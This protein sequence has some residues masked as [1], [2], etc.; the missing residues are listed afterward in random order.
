ML[1]LLALAGGARLVFANDTLVLGQAQ[2]GNIFLSSEPV[3]IPLQTTGDQISW[4]A[5]DFFGAVTTAPAMNVTNGQATVQPALGRLGFFKLHVTALRN[6]SP[7]AAADTML[8]VLAP[9]NVGAMHDSPFGINTHFAQGWSTDLMPLLARGGIAHFRDEQYWQNVEPARSLPATYNFT[10]YD[11]Y[12][13]A[14][15]AN[16][17]DPLLTLDFANS[18]YDGGYSPYTDEGR[19]GFANYG[20]ALISHA[21]SQIDTVAIWNE[22]NGSYATGPAANDRP[23]SYTS[24][25]QTAYTAIKAQHP[26]VRVVGGACVPVPLPWF[27]ELFSRGALDYLDAIDAH[28]YRSIP[29]GVENELAAVQALSA[30]YNHGRGPKPI[31]ATECG[32]DD[33]AHP[34]RE[35]MARYLVRL[36]TLMRTAGVERAYWYVAY[37]YD[38]YTTGLLHG[39]G[40]PLGAY[41][42]TSAFSAYSALIQQLYGATYVSR[43]QTDARTRSYYF[44]RGS[45]DV[46]VVW[47]TAGTAQLV[48]TTSTPLTRINIMG[49]ST[50]LQPSN[51]AVVVTADGDPY[52]LVGPVDAVR[53]IGRDT[54]I[55]DTVRDF[56][57]TQGSTAGNWSYSAT[58]TTPGSAYDPAALTPMTYTRTNF[59]YEFE[60]YFPF[61]KLDA[62]GGHPG[63]RLGYDPIYPVWSVRRWLSNTAANA[64]FNGTAVRAAIFGDGTGIKV[65]IDGAEVYSATLG[66]AGAAAT[67]TFDFDAPIQ[68]G[69]KV[70][71]VT[72]PGA[73]LDINYDYVDYRAVIS[74][75]APKPVVTVAATTAAASESGGAG[76]ITF[77]RTLTS[78]AL[79]VNYSL[80][81][82]ATA[83]IDYTASASSVTFPDGATTVPLTINPVRDNLA[84][85]DETVILTLTG[86][87]E[88]TIGTSATATVTIADRPGDAWRFGK[89][90]ASTPWTADP[91]G[92]GLPILL[93]YALG[94]D[95]LFAAP[96]AYPVYSVSNG[97]LALTYQRLRDPAEVSYVVEVSSGLVSWSS[98]PGFVA[99][100]LQPDGLTVIA[101]DLAPADSPKRFI[102]LRVIRP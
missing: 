86:S 33:N 11:P 43:D 95:P 17:L 61:S 14:A 55:A 35:N 91:F 6:G 60:S 52:Y 102:R 71:F 48:L 21:S 84:E 78:G 75:P 16:G 45:D 46:R 19:N 13:A 93:A 72:T 100:T 96:P 97:Q 87:T 77:T 3:R 66:G 90:L 64:H 58:Y 28:P 8:A 10:P 53:E 25:L 57:G 76:V 89:G 98:G 99:E 37:D 63:L 2:L 27:E 40:D 83:G 79:P 18:G 41:V 9:S 92:R 49:E 59:A 30:A 56:T 44:R 42:P 23:G 22:Y 12:I 65:F 39:P 51:G 88:Y 70:D 24:M 73:A 81:G 67:L 32:A 26:G 94:S 31:W 74:I 54:I 50:V 34:G 62:T 47:S 82:S 80:S 101:R 85:G 5:T 38:G 69:S 20:N 29:E 68:V 15:A 1:V 4:T 36:M 7:V